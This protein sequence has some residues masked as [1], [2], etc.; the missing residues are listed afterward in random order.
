MKLVN[1][2][3]L[4]NS[5]NNGQ[6]SNIKSNNTRGS[7]MTSQPGT[8]SKGKRKT[9]DIFNKSGHLN[10]SSSS[11]S[12][13][14]VDYCDHSPQNRNRSVFELHQDGE[15]RDV[16]DNVQFYID[17]MISKF[18]TTTLRRYVDVAPR[19]KKVSLNVPIDLELTAFYDFI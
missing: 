11:G 7:M 17:G 18:V 4:Q 15:H 19:L 16:L 1:R 2:P 10:G 8:A 13:A 12:I 6:K 3:R 5:S 14:L 9:D